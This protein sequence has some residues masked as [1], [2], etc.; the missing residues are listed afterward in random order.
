M[1]VASSRLVLVSYNIKFSVI[2][3]LH[4]NSAINNNFF[5]LQPDVIDFIIVN[6][7]M[8]KAAENVTCNNLYRLRLCLPV[9]DICSSKQISSFKNLFIA[10][11][12][13]ALEQGIGISVQQC[14]SKIDISFV[15]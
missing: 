7:G 12:I 5:D 4:F 15:G 14:R 9:G 3:K 2:G 13:D 11:I 10:V 6:V 8:S 1:N